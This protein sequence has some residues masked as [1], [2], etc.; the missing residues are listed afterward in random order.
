MVSTVAAL[1]GPKGT[2]KARE[3]LAVRGGEP[4]E[5][6]TGWWGGGNTG[7]RGEREAGKLDET[8]G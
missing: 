3:S 8:V 5:G 4:A 1:Q 2:R 7:F 6:Q